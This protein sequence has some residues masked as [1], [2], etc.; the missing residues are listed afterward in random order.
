[1]FR[2][3]L[4]RTDKSKTDRN[5]EKNRK[6]V[7]SPDAIGKGALYKVWKRRDM[8]LL[9]ELLLKDLEEEPLLKDPEEEL[10]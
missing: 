2:I 10:L 1:M 3:F 9:T 5:M 7:F 4:Y 6:T 8:H